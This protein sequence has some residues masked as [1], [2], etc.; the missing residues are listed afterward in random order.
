MRDE[1]LQF[2]STARRCSYDVINVPLVELRNE[3]CIG[4]QDALFPVSYEE[5]CVVRAHS[6]TTLFVAMFCSQIAMSRMYLNFIEREKYRFNRATDFFQ[7][8]GQMTQPAARNV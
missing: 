2:F 5:A 7:S 1:V 8:S 4:R 3:P 6:T